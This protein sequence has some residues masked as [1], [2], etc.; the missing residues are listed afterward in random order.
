MNDLSFESTSAYEDE[1]NLGLV[2]KDE[3]ANTLTHGLGLVLSF[4]GFACLF[5]TSYQTGDP[6]RLLNFSIYGGSL[7]ILYAASTLYHGTKHHKIKKMMRMFD[8]CAIYILIAGS[9]TPFTLLVI[10]DLWG[11]SL[12]IA[13]WSFALIGIFYKLVFKHRY[14]IFSTSL[15]LIMGWLAV[16][17]IEPFMNKFHQTGLF[18]IL[19]GGVCYT[20]GIIFYA[21]DKKRFF[22]AIWHLFVLAGSFCHYLAIFLYV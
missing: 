5:W 7:I 19:M 11:L 20:G 18:L 2:L 14:K 22:H 8:H 6:F 10:K 3:W 17:A 13:V 9:Y 16:I 21:L 12:F 4:V 15:Y 1:W